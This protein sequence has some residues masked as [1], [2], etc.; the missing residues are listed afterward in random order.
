MHEIKPT[1]N[2]ISHLLIVF[3]NATESFLNEIKCSGFTVKSIPQFE[4]ETDCRNEF[5]YS[6][7]PLESSIP[8]EQCYCYLITFD[9]VSFVSARVQR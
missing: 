2:V 3:V 4:L 5:K 7:Y 8:D 6:N 1:R 9:I